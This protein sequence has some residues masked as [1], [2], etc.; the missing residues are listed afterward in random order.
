MERVHEAGAIF[1]GPGQVLQLREFHQ[2]SDEKMSEIET[3]LEDWRS[4]DKLSFPD[5]TD[6]EKVALAGTLPYPSGGSTS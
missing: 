4:Q 2:A 5:L 3:L 6:D 1:S